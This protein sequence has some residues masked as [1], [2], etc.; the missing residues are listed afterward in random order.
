[1]NKRIDF[2]RSKVPSR[3]EPKTKP[4]TERVKEMINEQKTNTLASD[5]AQE[6]K[7]NGQTAQTLGKCLDRKVW[8]VP[9]FGESYTAKLTGCSLFN[10]KINLDDENTWYT[11]DPDSN[12]EFEKIIV[13]PILKTVEDLT[14]EMKDKWKNTLRVFNT[15]YEYHEAY[16][17]FNSVV[18]RLTKCFLGDLW[19]NGG[20]AIPDE[21]SPTGYISLH[22]LPEKL[23]CKRHSEVFK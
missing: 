23:S 5:N 4:P 3:P 8:V 19:N 9:E 10:N 21:E 17:T 6:S 22:D 16:P 2:D 12:S 15:I 1:M 11:L 13:Y 18:S 20:L 7:T 14:E